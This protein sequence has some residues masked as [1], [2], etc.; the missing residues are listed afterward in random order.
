MVLNQIAE[1]KSFGNCK[2]EN[3]ENGFFKSQAMGC[4]FETHNFKG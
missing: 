2:F 1:N 4:F 3:T